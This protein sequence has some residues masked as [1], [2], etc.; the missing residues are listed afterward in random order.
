MSTSSQPRQRRRR[1]SSTAAALADAA[2]AAEKKV[3]TA[4][5]QLWDELPHWRRDNAFILSGYRAVSNSYA[6]SLRSAFS[7][8]NES[9]NIWTHALGSLVLVPLAVAYLCADRGEVAPARAQQTQRGIASVDGGSGKMKV[10]AHCRLSRGTTIR[11]RRAPL[12]RGF[13]ASALS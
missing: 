2:S 1:S 7:V 10:H 11:N 6:A 3:S 4:L 9:V 12:V 5:L 13:A 8:H